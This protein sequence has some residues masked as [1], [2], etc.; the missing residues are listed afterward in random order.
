M[1]TVVNYSLISYISSD[2]YYI[3][4]LFA[5]EEVAAECVPVDDELGFNVNGAPPFY[6]IP[7]FV[8]VPG[9]WGEASSY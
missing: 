2:F 4:L 9:I 5:F 3:N 8:D 6:Y 1:S 7:D